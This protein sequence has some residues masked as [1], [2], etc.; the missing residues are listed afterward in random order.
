MQHS[1]GLWMSRYIGLRSTGRICESRRGSS[2]ANL[3]KRGVPESNYYPL[4]I[5]TTANGGEQIVYQTYEYLLATTAN[6]Q[7]ITNAGTGR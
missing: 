4:E 2:R 7:E 3:G 5:D 1:V 6:R